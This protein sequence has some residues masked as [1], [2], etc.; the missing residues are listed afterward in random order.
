MNMSLLIFNGSPR[1]EKSNSD[2]IISWFVEGFETP[3]TMYLKK[4]KQ[5]ESFIEKARSFDQLLFVFPLYVD[6]MPAQVK[7]FFE[8]MGENKEIFKDKKVSFIIH[9]GFSEAIH[10]KNLEKYLMRF[11]EIMEMKNY[12][13]F[14]IPGSEGFRIMPP[15]MTAKKARKVANIGRLYQMDKPFHKEDQAALEG[16]LVQNKTK[17]AWFKVMK[18]LGLTNFYWN[19]QLKKNNAFEK[20]FDA[21]YR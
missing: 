6:G 18:K 10:S 14:I 8:K 21:P 12:G 9:S 19:Q 13:V 4:V 2:I 7:V 17:V 3:S 16:P 11:V 15:R 20:R 5:H 1:G